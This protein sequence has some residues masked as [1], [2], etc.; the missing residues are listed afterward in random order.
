[1]FATVNLLQ[2][3]ILIGLVASAVFYVIELYSARQFFAESRN[4]DSAFR[5]AVSVLKPL[6]GLDIE[7]YENLATLCRQRYSAPFQLIFGVADES[8]PAIEIVRH[9][10]R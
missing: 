3:P 7:L 6:K 10:Q 9:L 2:L 8:D 4:A 5:P 1:V